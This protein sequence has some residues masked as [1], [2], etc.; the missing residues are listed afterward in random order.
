MTHIAE[1]SAALQLVVVP[2][3]SRN[4]MADDEPTDHQ[5]PSFVSQRRLKFFEQGR[6]GSVKA[7]E[8][9]RVGMLPHRNQQAIE[10]FVCD[11]ERLLDVNVFTRL[12]AGHCIVGV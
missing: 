7:R 10:L 12:D 1:N 11:S 9:S 6:P 3:I 5:R 2:M 4:R 8:Y